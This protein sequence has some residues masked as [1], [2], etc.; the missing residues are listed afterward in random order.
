MIFLRDASHHKTASCSDLYSEARKEV[1][2]GGGGMGEGED[3]GSLRERDRQTDRQ[4][5]HAWH[6]R[7]HM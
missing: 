5:R 1:E 4:T 2:S 3:G 6:V 7:K